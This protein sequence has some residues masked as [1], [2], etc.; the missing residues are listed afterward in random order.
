MKRFASRIYNSI[1]NPPSDEDLVKAWQQTEI[2]L[3]TI[4][5]LG[6]TGAGKST[7]VQKLT[8]HSNA[9]IGNG[10]MPCTQASSYFDYPQ[11][12][13]ILR[14]LDTR[15]LGEVSYQADDDL[16]AMSRTSHS[17]LVVSRIRDGEQS[18]VVNA[19]KQ[20]RKSSKHIRTASIIVVHTGANEILNE[21]DMLRAVEAKQ[22]SIEAV[23]GKA[24]D[25]CIVDFSEIDGGEGLN[26]IGAEQ[27]KE[28]ISGKIPE[29][30]LWLGVQEHNDAEKNNFNRLRTNVLWYAGT[31]A[32]S[33]TIP[34]FGLVS[35]PAI[36]GK[37]L[38]SLAQKYG[39]VWNARNFSEFTAALGSSFALRYAFNLAARQLGKLIP[40][41][42]Q[43]L[44]TACAVGVSYA[45]T[46]ALGRA[47]CSYLYHKKTGTPVGD[48]VKTVYSDAL[49]EGKKAGQ[50]MFKGPREY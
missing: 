29:L 1:I 16:A 50:E 44:G 36:Q 25:S 37:M 23:W 18:T 20:I 24:L 26:D 8:G 22:K 27:L 40:G 13:P 28:M 33:D 43:I 5:L 34:M 46:Y 30:R 4:W 31:A 41:Y 38:H 19:L 14:F 17:L 48:E 35:V 21:H 3:P 9:E 39:M 47:A 32:A 12:H 49:S 10:F 7:I 15:G 2:L 6:K 42:G 11:K 45:G